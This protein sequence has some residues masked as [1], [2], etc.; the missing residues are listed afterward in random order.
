MV[1]QILLKILLLK[2]K[3]SMES[4]GKLRREISRRN[5]REKEHFETEVMRA[6][7]SASNLA[8]E[9]N[10]HDLEILSISTEN[11]K[12]LKEDQAFQLRSLMGN[13]AHDL[14]V[15]IFIYLCEVTELRYPLTFIPKN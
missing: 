15:H 8:N 2:V 13:V 9:K 4:E 1:Y 7:L 10:R 6:R 11:E 3:K 5:T 14:K 12:I